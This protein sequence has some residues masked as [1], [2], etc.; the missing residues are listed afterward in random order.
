MPAPKAI[1]VLLTERL[2]LRGLSRRDAADV[3]AYASNPKVLHFTTGRTP[4]T[5]EDVMAFLDGLLASSPSEFAWA[6]RLREE[7]RVIGIVEFGLGDGMEGTVH[8]ALAAE[9]WNRGLMTEA[10]RMVLAWAFDA[11]SGL[12][13]VTTSAVVDNRGSTRVMEKCGMT[14]REIVE[15]QWSKFDKPTRLAVYSVDRAA[16]SATRYV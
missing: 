13:R 15:E 1:P 9:Q 3:F 5:V 10:C 6:I 2:A 4:Q 8:Y 11:H 12:E 14:F 16:F 7:P